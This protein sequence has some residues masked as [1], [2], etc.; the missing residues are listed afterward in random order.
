[1]ASKKI[2]DYTKRLT[3]K[4]WK[5]IRSHVGELK[6]FFLENIGALYNMVDAGMEEEQRRR[7]RNDK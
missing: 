3:Y 2:N 6:A 7:R 4:R 1:V 5:K